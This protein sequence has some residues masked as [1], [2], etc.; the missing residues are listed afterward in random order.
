MDEEALGIDNSIL[1]T[2][3]QETRRITHLRSKETDQ[4]SMIG[5]SSHVL[6]LRT[7]P[8]RFRHLPVNAP[9]FPMLV[10]GALRSQRLCVARHERGICTTLR[11][12][13]FKVNSSPQSHWQ[14]GDGAAPPLS[15]VSEKIKTIEVK[16]TLPRCVL[17]DRL[18]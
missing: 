3:W 15:Y 11:A 8:R 16:D 7:E 17:G 18:M 2:W 1:E 14:V 10:S 9:D 13:T 6:G 5:G 4:S 12:L